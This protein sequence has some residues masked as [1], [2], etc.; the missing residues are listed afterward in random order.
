MLNTATSLLSLLVFSVLMPLESGVDVISVNS[1]A[2]KRFLEIAV[3]LKR[4]VAV[5]TDN[6]RKI[7]VLNAKYAEYIGKPGVSI[8]YDN[9]EAYPTLEPQLL[10]ANGRSA[11]EKVLGKVFDSDADLLAYMKDNKADTALK[12]FSTQEAWVVPEYIVNAIS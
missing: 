5:V 3:R 2:F 12:F 6:D 9:D 8:H 10:K 4:T 7:A 11:I 1:L